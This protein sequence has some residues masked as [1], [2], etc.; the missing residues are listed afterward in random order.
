MRVPVGNN[1]FPLAG[2]LLMCQ[3]CWLV[4]GHAG[5]GIHV[6]DYIWVNLVT[7]GQLL[8]ESSSP[9]GKGN[10]EKQLCREGGLKSQVGVIQQPA[11]FW[12]RR[13]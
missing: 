2:Q 8:D 1:P 3:R 11:A 10:L 12:K 6:L 5:V 13:W 7:P 4:R 9:E